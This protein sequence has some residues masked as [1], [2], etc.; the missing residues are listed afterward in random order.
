MKKLLFLA[1]ATLAFAACGNS[2]S[3]E[4]TEVAT[5][6]VE[7]V[8]PVQQDTTAAPVQDTTVAPVQEVK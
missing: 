4:N 8:A 1:V 3:Q 5:P 6:V 7:E 2:G